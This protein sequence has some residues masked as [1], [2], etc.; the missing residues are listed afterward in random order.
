[1]SGEA[2]RDR[3]VLLTALL[4]TGVSA[5]T[6]TA[7]PPVAVFAWG[8]AVLSGLTALVIAIRRMQG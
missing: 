1:M 5:V 6:A 8:A 2:R 3:G 4:L 7:F